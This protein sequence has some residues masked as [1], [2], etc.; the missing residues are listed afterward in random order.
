MKPLYLEMQAFGPYKDRQT[1]DFEKLSETGIFLI[2]GPTGSGKTTIIDA[3]T[4]AL[5]GGG[6]TENDKT[7]SGRNDILQW[8]CSQSEAELDTYTTFIFSVRGHKYKFTRRLIQKRKN[9]V[10]EY[11]AGEIDEDGA[12]VPFF[13]NPRKDDLTKK[14]EE[15]IGLD[16]EQ[17]RQVVL[18]PQGQFERFLTAPSGDKEDILEKIFNAKS[19]KKYAEYFYDEVYERKNILEQEKNEIK[20][21]LKEEGFESMDELAEKIKNLEEEKISCI[22]AHEEYEGD[23]KQELLN[24]DRQLAEQFK[25]LNDLKKEKA[26]LEKKKG[27]I[28]IKRIEY[29]QAQKAEKLRIPVDE[30]EKAEEE[31]RRR[32]KALKKL[33]CLI[34]EAEKKKYDLEKERKAYDNDSEKE[35]LNKRI[36]YLESKREIYLNIEPLKKALKEAG[37]QLE[38][39]DG[40]LR[41]SEGELKAAYEKAAEEKG[42]FDAALSQAKEYRDRYYE[43]IY[44]QIAAELK[45]HKSCPV[46]G[47]E[48]HPHP[49]QKPADSISREDLEKKE[50]AADKARLIW[51]RAE[52]A[53]LKIEEDNKKKKKYF[54]EKKN[55]YTK[56][57]LK[58]KAA[59]ENLCS[60]IS[61]TES[62][63]KNIE[64]ARRR[65]EAYEKKG[66]ALQYSLN[67]A[68]EELSA[69]KENIKA[70]D[71][72]EKN[73][74]IK[75]KKAEEQ[76]NRLLCENDIEDHFSVKDKLADE[77]RRKELHEEIVKYDTS[78]QNTEAALTEKLAEL[79]GKTEPDTSQFDRRQKDINTELA[80]HNRKL[81]ELKTSIERLKK[82]KTVLECK[83]KHFDDN[84]LVA[85]EDMA[86]A[87]KLRGDSSIGIQ[88]YVLAVMFNQVISEANR[89]LLRVHGGRYQLFRSDEKGVGNK[90]GLELKVYD[91]LSP[92]SEG[93]SVAM[94]SGGEKFLVSL[95]LS[96]GMSTVAQKGGVQVQALFID[97]GFGTLDEASIYDAMDVLDSVRKGT[98]TIGI[99]SH[100]QLL[101]SNIPV[102]LNVLKS[103]DGSRIVME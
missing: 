73:A 50:K 58:Y 5:Y 12:V 47:S 20:A 100:V 57:E 31:Y 25:P 35:D 34:P 95:A 38:E 24:K 94:L 27:L 92:E 65:I 97:E 43:G 59:S 79:S 37:S 29:E 69:L 60:D 80:E 45:D 72:E 2:K 1:V 51:N 17:F 9:L 19:W 30:Y 33:A 11:E 63:E 21:S 15:L 76:L 101:E 44:G 93:R 53:R 55:E 102:H 40:I 8:R 56:T 36:V 28:E 96:I 62:L 61:D 49:A 41:S 87:R 64:D 85:E 13:E 99:I 103:E 86:F 4:Y 71:A 77:D 48:E 22:R 52:E 14:A 46:C 54:E 16:K 7:K 68:A 10:S 82:K 83:K 90:R 6:S 74:L 66:K 81:S 98:G 3:M 39:A 89:M 67:M 91:S 84:I 26:G 18:L 78:L 70:A 42:C 23:R 32:E 88:R 75:L